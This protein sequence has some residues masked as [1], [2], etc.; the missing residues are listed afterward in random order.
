MEQVQS[1]ANYFLLH[2]EQARKCTP[3]TKRVLGEED[4]ERLLADLLHVRRSTEHVERHASA[5]P[6]GI[7]GAHL[8]QRSEDRI[9]RP[10]GILET[11]NVIPA[12]GACG[13]SAILLETAYGQQ[14]SV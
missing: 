12:Q 3:C 10:P 9:A 6:I 4:V 8:L 7:A 13:H 5:T 2:A 1:H 14:A 11:H